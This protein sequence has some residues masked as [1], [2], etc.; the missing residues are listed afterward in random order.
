[1]KYALLMLW[2]ICDFLFGTFLIGGSIWMVLYKHCSGWWVAIAIVLCMSP[3]L[4]K[5]LAKE[6]GV[7]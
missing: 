4:Y 3:T 1:M 2:I 6:F 5:V 7:K